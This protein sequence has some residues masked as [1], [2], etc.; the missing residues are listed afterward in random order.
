MEKN[1]SVIC[2]IHG[3]LK[4]YHSSDTDVLTKKWIKEFL[5]WPLRYLEMFI[6]RPK[7]SKE[8]R[9]KALQIDSDLDL[10]ECSW[11][12][13]KTIMRDPDRSI[14]HYDHIYPVSQ[15]RDTLIDL[16]DPHQEDKS[17]ATINEEIE[18]E[19]SKVGIAWILKSEDKLLNNAGYRSKRPPDPLEAY[20]KVGIDFYFGH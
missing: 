13:Q 19:L 20:G 4:A 18:K 11:K 1:E 10:S 9:E 5:K 15:L 14:F 7:V 8:A 12:D 16:S 6:A 3:L 17:D 2:V